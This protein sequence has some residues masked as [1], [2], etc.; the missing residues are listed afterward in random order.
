MANELNATG[1]WKEDR[2]DTAIE[3][4]LVQ[5][6]S[7]ITGSGTVTV[8]QRHQMN[9]TCTGT[10]SG[11]KVTLSGR[12]SNGDHFQFDGTYDPP[13]DTLVDRTNSKI[14]VTLRRS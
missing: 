14:T 6:G 13:P 4:R 8:L 1:T 11:S 5:N 12:F 10:A 2:G 7:D 9:F 3:L